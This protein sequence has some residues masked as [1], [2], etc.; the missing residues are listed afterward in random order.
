MKL[1]ATIILQKTKGS[2]ASSMQENEYIYAFNYKLV[3]N[4]KELNVEASKSA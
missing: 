2:L 4:A 3:E 1:N